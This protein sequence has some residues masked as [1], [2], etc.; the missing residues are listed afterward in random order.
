VA[1]GWLCRVLGGVRGRERKTYWRALCRN[2]PTAAKVGVLGS[3]DEAGTSRGRASEVEG[4]GAVPWNAAAN[5]A[6]DRALD[7]QRYRHGQALEPTARALMPALRHF[8][9]PA[10][11][12][13]DRRSRGKGACPTRDAAAAPKESHSRLARRREGCAIVRAMRPS[14]TSRDR[15]PVATRWQPKPPKPTEPPRPD[16]ASERRFPSGAELRQ[17]RLKALLI[18]RS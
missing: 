7:A 6:P 5:H 15:P 3:G 12:N 4:L 1:E 17:E 11:R 8:L 14:T 9:A 16:Y 13:P 18:P 10:S 2:S